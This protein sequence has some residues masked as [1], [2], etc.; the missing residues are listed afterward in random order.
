MTPHL[1]RATLCAWLFALTLLLPAAVQAQTRAWLD[2]AQV[3]AGETVTLNIQTDSDGVP[4]YAPLRTDFDVGAQSR[5]RQVDWVNGRMQRR[6]VHGVALVPRRVGTLNIPPL[7]VGTAQTTAL[8]LQVSAARP[9]PSDGTAAAFVETVV[10][11]TT[12]YA[13]QSVGVVVRLYYATQLSSGTLVLDTPE[14]ASLQMVGEDRSDVREVGGRRYNVAER[15]YLMIPERSGPLRVPGARFDGRTV[16]TFFDDVFGRADPTLRAVAPDQTLQV[17]AQPADAPQPWLP[18]HDLRLRYT[19]APDRAR[20]GEAVTLDVEAIA[21][22]ATRAQFTGLPV[23]DL[24]PGAQVFAEPPQYTETFTGS[25]PQLKITQRYAIVPR[26]AGTLTVPGLRM[27]WWDVRSG[28]ARSTEL[29]DVV[30]QVAQGSGPAATPSAPAPVD[31]QSALPGDGAGDDMADVS[32][33]A[34]GN[35]MKAMPWPWMAAV[36]GL[37]VLWL[38]TLFWGWRRGRRDDARLAPARTGPAAATFVPRPLDRAARAELRRALDTEGLAEVA[39]LL[40][41]M[42]GVTRLEQ[43][44]ERLQDPRQRE[45]LQALQQARWAGQGDVPAVRRQLKEAFQKGP[46]WVSPTAPTTSDLPPLYPP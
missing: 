12:P 29:A 28:Q 9:A 23:P 4:D 10:D 32:P 16:G 2:R 7:Q 30:L 22:G 33:A 41:A 5:N 14:G 27:R 39:A 45:A 38:L 24:G 1:S 36:G 15:R 21:V 20:S 44:I 26:A 25:S 11:D 34:G 3:E 37:L 13:Q 42:A 18:L 8:R 31:T 43:V 19:A 40:C 17:Q 35:A 6:T 46:Q